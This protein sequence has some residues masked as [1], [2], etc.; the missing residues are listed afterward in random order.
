MN[1]ALTS[2]WLPI[3]LSAIAVF[4]ASS[5]IW[6]VVGYHSSDWQKLQNED[7]AQ[8][9]LRGTPVGQYSIPHAANMAERESDDFKK[10]FASGPAAMLVVMRNDS[11]SMGRQLSQWFAYCVVASTLIAYVASATL[12]A[13]TA[14]M[15]VFQVVGSVA[16]LTYGG[17][18]AIGSIWFGFTWS[19]SIKDIV[20]ATVYGLL[21]AGI[22]GWLWP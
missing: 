4:F 18:A 8:N 3:L 9:T 10:K 11:M 19:K 14:Y 1:I 7:D 5:V 21:T 2:L 13:D 15:K 6:M 16:I 20:D 17:A 22:F 12:A